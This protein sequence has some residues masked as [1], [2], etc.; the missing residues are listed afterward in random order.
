MKKLIVL[1]LCC[2]MLAACRPASAPAEDTGTE[3]TEPVTTAAQ[4]APATLTV[5]TPDENAEQFLQTQVTVDQVNETAILSALIDVGVLAENVTVN[6]AELSG[7]ELR[8]D[9]NDAFRDQLLSLGTAGEYALM[10]SLIN[11]FLTAY[12]DA[13]TLSVTVDG[14][15]LESGH[16]VYDSPLEFF[17]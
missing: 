5:F 9:L 6:S 16:A 3:T 8:L 12:P 2:L 13:R 11:T 15:V 14:A 1:C 4:A 7:E 17:E 10:G